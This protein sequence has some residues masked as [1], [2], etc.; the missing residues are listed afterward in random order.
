MP[1]VKEYFRYPQEINTIVVTTL[2]VI[3]RAKF[4]HFRVTIAEALT[5]GDMVGFYNMRFHLYVD[6]TQLYFSFDIHDPVS[7]GQV[8]SKHES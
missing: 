6:D 3:N 1:Y 4:H 8:I 2:S 5:F 7:K